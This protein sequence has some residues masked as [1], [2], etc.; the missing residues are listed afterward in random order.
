MFYRIATGVALIAV[1]MASPAVA[2]PAVTT[3]E[4]ENGMDVVVIED[5]R[6]PVVT[7]MVWYPVGSADEPWGTS[8]IAH[9]FEHMMFRGSERFPNGIASQI[10]AEN[11]GVENAFTSYDY[12]AYFQTIAADRLDIVMDLES[13]RMRNLIINEDVT[14]T[15]RKVILEERNQ[16]TDSSPQA[17]FSEQ[18]RAALFM[19]HPYGV[20]IIGWRH[21]IEALS[22]EDLTNFYNAYYSPD[23]A[24]LVVAGDVTPDQV[25]GLAEKYY[26]PLP[27]SG[28]APEP[29]PSE[30]PQ[31]AARRLEMSDHRVRQEYVMRQYLV[32]SYS[33]ESPKDSA[34]LLLLSEV[35]GDG[36]SSRFAEKLQLQDKTAIATGAFYS[37]NSRD[38]SV[39][40]IYG[41]PT[42]VTD[43]DTVE[44]SLDAVIAELVAN[45]PTE[46]ELNRIKRLL[47]ASRIYAEDSLTS[48]ARLYGSSLAVGHTVEDIDRWPEIVDSVTPEDVRAAAEKY[49]DISHSVT[50]RLLRGEEAKL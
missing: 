7:Q 1:T 39:F 12:T 8:G 46:E 30:P 45:G 20:P 29:R 5:H 47:K 41:V 27:V 38:A 10:I 19:N 16:R 48:Q 34:A 14:A 22:V 35:L 42:P 50:G 11:G 23:N 44:D 49:L 3:F 25:R 26:G 6:A 24:I 4:L 28:Q 21:E 37:P 15:E 36:I 43:L 40:G 13:D 2:E 17:L 9:F 31:L 18:M 32:P 33:P